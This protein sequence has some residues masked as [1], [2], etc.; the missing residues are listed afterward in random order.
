VSML[1]VNGGK[2]LSGRIAAVGNKNAVLPMI[3]AALLTD[4]DVR[5]SN[6]PNIDDVGVML[7]LAAAL[8][9]SV[10]RDSA[11]RTVCLRA[12]AVG[13]GELPRDLCREIRAG[14]LFAAPLL[15]RCGA[16]IMSPPG[17]DVI[18]RRRLDSH[19]YGLECLGATVEMEERFRFRAPVRMS[20][21]DIFLPEASVTA[22][23]QVLMGAVLSRGTTVIRNAATEPHISDLARMLGTM[24]ARITGVDSNVLRI[25]GVD[26]LGGCTHR[27]VSDHT[28]A[29]SFLALAAA[30]GGSVELTGVDP[31]HYRMTERVLARLGVGL[32]YGESSVRVREKS[33]R[34]VTGDLGSGIPVIDDGPW[35]Q[36]PSDLM[37]VMIVLATQVSGTVLFFEKM[38]ESRMYFVDRLVAM[39]A[40]AVICD[41]HRVVVCGPSRLHGISLSSPDIRAGMALIGAA[42]CADGESTIKNVELVDRGY[43]C[44][45][46][47]LRLLGAEVERL[48]D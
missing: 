3:A 31:E 35:P 11:G 41:P 18:G 21:A 9:V 16:A 4:E 27:I 8:G 7:E 26:R 45:D 25:E 38:Y 5:L 29:G 32:E 40:N 19:V 15:H 46:E 28:E 10:E 33:G 14:I 42:L 24:G 48:D 12:A 39:G 30:T 36:F 43:E 1:R 44:I 23:A 13:R 20:G 37:S 17:G 47:R 22:T 2:P 6:V 34:C